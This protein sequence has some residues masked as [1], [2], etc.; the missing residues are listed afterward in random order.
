MSNEKI[1]CNC[2]FCNCDCFERKLLL[3]EEIVFYAKKRR[4]MKLIRYE[5]RAFT[6]TT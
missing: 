5:V 6:N 1:L 4:V 2:P 3:G